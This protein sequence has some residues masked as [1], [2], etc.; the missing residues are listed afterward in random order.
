[1]KDDRKELIKVFVDLPNHWLWKGESMWARALGS[2]LY[3]L[4]NSPFCAYGLNYKD[5]VLARAQSPS[6][7][8][9]ICRVERC[10]GHRTLRL[11]FPAEVARS[12]R[13]SMLAQLN[14]L[15]T[16]FEGHEYRFFSLDVPPTTDYQAICDQL[17]AWEADGVLEYETC[18]ER[19][20]GSFDD[21]PDDEPGATER[22]VPGDAS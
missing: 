7:K 11:R 17:F 5:V 22:P 16:S 13:D 15:G 21:A 9:R 2:D 19:M 14:S 6:E 18:E 1:M 3:E 10:S 4:E 12:D 20:P 8:P